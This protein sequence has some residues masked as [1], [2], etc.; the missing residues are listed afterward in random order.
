M[1]RAPISQLVVG[2]RY[3]S[4]R[5]RERHLGVVCDFARLDVQPASTYH[6]GHATVPAVDLVCGHKFERRSERVSDRHSV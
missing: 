6:L 4:F 5:D 2:V 3:D 1:K